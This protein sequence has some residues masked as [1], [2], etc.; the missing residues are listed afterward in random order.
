MV[1]RREQRSAQT[2]CDVGI[3]TVDVILSAASRIA[4]AIR[5]RQ[6]KNPY[7]LYA[8]RVRKV[9]EGGTLLKF[10]TNGDWGQVRLSPNWS[11]IPVYLTDYFPSC[12]DLTYS[13]A[14]P[15]SDATNV[16]KAKSAAGSVYFPLKPPSR[17]DI[18]KHAES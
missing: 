18:R 7:Q 9:G 15:T 12:L 13:A 2:I 10:S 1:N 3:I 6:S 8:S 11:R 17:L 5:F 16:A 4:S 14:L